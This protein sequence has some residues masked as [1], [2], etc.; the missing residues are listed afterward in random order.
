VPTLV[1]SIFPIAESSKISAIL[2]YAQSL[3]IQDNVLPSNS[4]TADTLD[5]SAVTKLHNGLA[6]I[7]NQ[8]NIQNSINNLPNASTIADAV[9]NVTVRTITDKTNFSLSSA[10]QNTLVTAIEAALLNDGD[11]QQLINA[12]LQV[13][14]T[15]LDLPALE[16]TAIAQAVRTELATELTR[17]DA[18]ITSR[19]TFNKDT[20]TV[21][22]SSIGTDVIN[23]SSINANA[24]TKVQN[25]LATSSSISSLNNLSTSQV[26]TEI[27]NALIAAD[28]TVDLTPVTT[29]LDTIQ[30]KTDK[31]TFSV[32]NDILATLDGENVT[33]SSTSVTDIKSGLATSANQTNIANSISGLN[34]LSTLEV[35]TVVDDALTAANLSVDLDPVLT[36]IDDIPV[37]V[38]NQLSDNFSNVSVDLSPIQTDLTAIK[39]KTDKLTFTVDNKVEANATVDTENITVDVDFT[40]VLEAIDNIDCSGNDYPRTTGNQSNGNI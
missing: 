27:D 23:A 29:Q 11:G 35:R 8:T 15:S 9:W 40:E 19:S 31:L 38:E 20:D 16:L 21:S 1:P 32:T 5:T 2:A 37:N 34:D 3:Y 33:V 39:T 13:I 4:I 24:V 18:N 7:T 36:A 12:I 26:R 10:Y 17:I 28:L 30:N 14:N 22:V 25:G 6:T